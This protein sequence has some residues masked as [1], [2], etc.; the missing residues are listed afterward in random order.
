MKPIRAL[1]ALSYK[2]DKYSAK[3]FERRKRKYIELYGD[4]NLEELKLESPTFRSNPELLDERI[5]GYRQDLDKLKRLYL[6]MKEKKEAPKNEKGD[7]LTSFLAKRCAVGIAAEYMEWCA[8]F[9]QSS[10]KAM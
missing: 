5:E 3:E 9:S 2:K 6:S 1:I 4:R 8:L 10:V 7:L